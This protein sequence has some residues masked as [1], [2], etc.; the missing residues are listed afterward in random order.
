MDNVELVKTAYAAFGRGDI[1]AIL[2]LL[3]DSVEWSCPLTLPQGGAFSGK[4]GALQFFQGLGGAWDPLQVEVKT[5]G[6]ITGDCVVAVVHGSGQ[7]RSGGPAGYGA[8]HVFTLRGSKI[9]RFQEF[10][11]VDKPLIA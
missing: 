2:D 11:D 9:V 4:D 1:P 8:A 10:V 7:L 5:L 6:A 3:D